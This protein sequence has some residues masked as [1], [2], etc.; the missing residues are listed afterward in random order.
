MK[1]HIEKKARKDIDRLPAVIQKQMQNIL[2]GILVA[3]RL[4][5]I[6]NCKML[7]GDKVSYSIRFGK[8]RIGIKYKGERIDIYRVLHR[9]DI[10]SKFP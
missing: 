5:D 9:K 8:Y 6:V 3:N 1:I 7:R 10:Y 2:I 4:E